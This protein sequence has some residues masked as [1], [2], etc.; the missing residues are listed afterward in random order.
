[1]DRKE[2]FKI[3]KEISGLEQSIDKE[4]QLIQ[5][6]NKRGLQI[7]NLRED[8]K[9][10]L[11]NALDKLNFLETDF[12]SLEKQ[13]ISLTDG[14]DKRKKD[15]DTADYSH[16]QKLLE[17]IKSDEITKMEMDT[18][19]LQLIEEIADNQEEIKNYETF[20]KGSEFTLKDI[21]LEVIKF[22]DE[23]NIIIKRLQDRIHS[24]LSELPHEF[25]TEIKRLKKLKIKNS[26]FTQITNH[27]C[28]HCHYALSRM[29]EDAV[30]RTLSLVNCT[31]C[32][33]LFIPI[34]SLYA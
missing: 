19:M 10:A 29:D 27:Q 31:S 20:L 7:N 13:Y 15:L 5:E 26:P 11:K 2:Y 17:Q 30:E 8:N 6:E 23:K 28:A 4:M 16:Q 25:Q 32:G 34:N 33:R 1:M 14:I 21:E 24:L 18:N 22:T 3:L 12:N 9:I